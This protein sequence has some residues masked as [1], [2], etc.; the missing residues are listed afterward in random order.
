MAPPRSTARLHFA[1]V[2]ISSEN[3]VSI[4]LI[5]KTTYNQRN[6]CSLHVFSLAQVLIVRGCVYVQQM[7]H[8]TYKWIGQLKKTNYSWCSV[9]VAFPV[10]K[11]T[12]F[13]R[14]AWSA[15]WTKL[16]AFFVLFSIRLAPDAVNNSLEIWKTQSET[17]HCD[18]TESTR[19]A[20]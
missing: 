16:N 11:K 20:A 4:W 3:R 15:L 10:R 13:L 18:R 6:C 7:V 9:Y 2:N 19:S 8:L 14:G 1:V 17:K 5:K 12:P